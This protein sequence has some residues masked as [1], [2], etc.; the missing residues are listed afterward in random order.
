[1]FCLW[2]KV[3]TWGVK[4][5]ESTKLELAK[6][7][8]SWVDNIKY[9]LSFA[10]LFVLASLIPVSCLSGRTVFWQMRWVWGRPS[11][12]S[13]CCRRCTPR[14]SKALSW[15][16]LRSP[17]SPT[18]RGSSPRGPTWTPSCTTA[19][20]PA[21]RWS[22]STRCTARMIRWSYHDC[23]LILQMIICV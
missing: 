8:P 4:H 5:N 2:S 17:P 22:S 12:P 16:S 9:F 1:M 10:F 7:N 19:A 6:L 11:S 14:A 23:S 21:D 15:S 3:S 18:G 13:R 20:W